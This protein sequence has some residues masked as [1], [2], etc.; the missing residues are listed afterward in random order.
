[1][2]N[3]ISRETQPHLGQTSSGLCREV[4]DQG[5]VDIFVQTI[6]LS[7]SFTYTLLIACPCGTHEEDGLVVVDHDVH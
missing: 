5:L 1:M 7:L 6:H 2:L 4:D 3:L